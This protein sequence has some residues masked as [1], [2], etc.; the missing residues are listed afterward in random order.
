MKEENRMEKRNCSL[1]RECYTQAGH[2]QNSNNSKRNNNK[3]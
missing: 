1:R 3:F 2:K